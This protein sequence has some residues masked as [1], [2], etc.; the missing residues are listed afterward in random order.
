MRGKRL[1]G[2]T[3]VTALCMIGMLYLNSS[4]SKAYWVTVK[5]NNTRVRNAASTDSEVMTG[6]QG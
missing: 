3:I 1:V 4:V 5:S 2:G 6:G